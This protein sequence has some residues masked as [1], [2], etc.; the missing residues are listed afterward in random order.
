MKEKHL[1][2]TNKLIL[3]VHTITT[4]FGFIGLMSQLKM[5]TT[6]K[7][8][9][10][11]I[12]IICLLVGYIGGVVVYTKKKNTLVY[13]KYVG[14]AFSV[15]Y[16][17][18]LVLGASGASFPYMIPFLLVFIFALDKKVILIPS[19]VFVIT[20]LIRVI[21]TFS[22][23]EVMDEVI[24]SASIE[25]IITILVTVSTFQGLKLLSTFFESSFGEVTE[26]AN[27]NQ[28]VATEIVNVA[29]SVGEH[30]NTMNASLEQI[31]SFNSTVNEKMNYI[32]D[33]TT[34]TAEAVMNQT[35]QTKEIQDVIDNTHDSTEK[36]VEITQEA[37][38]A[39]EE[40]T[41]AIKDLFAQVD[42]SI[43]ES[44]E[45][46]RASAEL[47]QKTEQV[48]GITSIILGISAQTNLL[49][50]NASIEAARAGDFG[51]G[52][53]VVA[54]E[55]RN[56]AEQTRKETE[57]ITGLIE[58]LSINA[59]EVTA[60]VEASVES[61]NKENEC[62]SIASEKFEEITGKIT[63]LSAEIVGI[64][65]KVSSL[66]NANNVIVD[67][68]NTLSAT[69]EEI[70]ASSQ[71]ASEISDRNV[72]MLKEFA[73]IMDQLTSEVADLRQHTV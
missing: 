69:S 14:I 16:F 61:S 5:S 17:F 11:I 52:F 38:N 4:L 24:E 46:Q 64:S 35:V 21:E 41:T 67:S 68:V 70:S 56:L 28:T 7:P 9:Q 48:R 10:S 58:E 62:A 23:T 32:V 51:K 33:G 6:T 65:E 20:N 45:M 55:I 25:I 42:A 57:N 71:E 36:I 37:K 60:R 22:T 54:D 34:E 47:K 59:Q 73:Q 2:R 63:E 50:L 44:T 12:P 31:L 40:G 30:A 53:A 15:P 39:L 8:I 1:L 27:K 66:R 72:E 13:T 3:L 18:M 29:A 26:A 19:I 43:N 49:A